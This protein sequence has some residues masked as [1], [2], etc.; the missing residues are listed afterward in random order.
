MR[1]ADTKA[2]RAE[3]R[4][5]MNSK[6]AAW[7]SVSAAALLLCSGCRSTHPPGKLIAS[8]PFPDRE[9][10]AVAVSEG[11]GPV[12]LSQAVS[13]A[14]ATHPRIGAMRA[15]VF[16]ASG[17]IAEAVTMR[18]PE[19]NFGFGR[20]DEDSSGWARETETGS[21]RRSGSE[22]SSS[23]EAGS[24]RS[25]SDSWQGGIFDESSSGTRDSATESQG[26]QS[27]RRNTR[28]TSSSYTVDV[29]DQNEDSYRLGL[30]YF[31]PNP[32]LLSA[33]GA[34][35]RA[36]RWMAQAELV[37]EEHE[38]ICDTVEAALKIAYGERML[39]VR[40]AFAEDC[41]AIHEEVRRAMEEGS[42]SRSDYLD[43][44]L[45]LTAADAD[46]EREAVQLASWRQRFRMLTGVEPGRVTFSEVEE[47]AICTLQPED[48]T[49]RLEELARELAPQRPDVLAAH[50]NTLLYE[51]EWR[52]AR[53]ANYPWFNSVEVSYTRWDSDD[54]RRRT[55]ESSRTETSTT[56]QNSER[57]TVRYET[58]ERTTTGGDYEAGASEGS[59]LQTASSRSRETEITSGFA[60][61]TAYGS[62]DGDE[63][64]VGFSVEIPIF[65]W[66]SGQRSERVKALEAARSGH[67]GILARA[68][69]EITLAGQALQKSWT[70]MRKVSKAFRND[71]KE[72]EDLVK[73]SEE[74]GLPGRLEALRLQ[75]RGAEL[76]ILSLDRALSVALDEL[77]FCRVSGL[78]P[79][80][81]MPEK[82]KIDKTP[83]R[84]EPAAEDVAEIPADASASLVELAW[85]MLTRVRADIEQKNF[86]EADSRLD[87]IQILVP[88]FLPAY[89]E[90]ARLYEC[91]G[92]MKEA[93]VQWVE[94]MKRSQEN[95]E[96]AVERPAKGPH[97]ASGAE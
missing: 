2:V 89:E 67:A 17:N 56:S 51:G 75:E 44:R 79:G 5:L 69:R 28:Y 62:S 9:E 47:G 85:D 92:M 30:R 29:E 54:R 46:R 52:E 16:R 8:S 39:K 3:W 13:Y 21:S 90:R 6:R 53:A 59:S 86:P 19:L 70:D 81:P 27:S 14:L 76:A 78:A 88:D 42:I 65:E 38:L 80:Q 32:W 20:E 82:T 45:R 93:E 64:W 35:A 24:E 73:A 84:P 48:G 22:S 60:T 57:Q 83:E 4:R 43:A 34:A 1:R 66:M 77:Y 36:E 71:R 91:R 72:I 95:P 41:L 10:L 68:E 58:E 31:P 18:S 12:E 23:S 94:M 40:E 87:R 49:S 50:W 15:Q 7:V 25:A 97:A 33:A 61:E 11:R 26:S 63:W 55:V 96:Y 37:V 74:L